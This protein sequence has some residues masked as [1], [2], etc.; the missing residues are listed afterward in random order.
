MGV[1]LKNVFTLFF[2]I[3][4]SGC[5]VVMKSQREEVLPQLCRKKALEFEE[6]GE[7][8][9]ALFNWKILSELNYGENERIEKKIAELQSEALSKAENHF[10][11][12]VVFYKNNSLKAARKEFLIVLRYNPNHKNAYA[13][14]KRKLSGENTVIYKVKEGDTL[15]DIAGK[16]Y[17][18][19]GKDFLIACFTGLDNGKV[20]AKG[21]TLIL[22][23]LSPELTRRLMDVEKRISEA[24]SYFETNEFEK[25]LNVVCDVL[26]Y[27]PN[28]K[29]A[30][31]LA[32]ASRYRIGKMLSLKKEYAHSLEMLNQI[33][34]G[35]EGV[36][37]AIAD[38][39]NRM[40]EQAEVHYTKGVKYFVN[41]QLK[42]AI[43]EWEKALALN[44]GHQKAKESVENAQGLLEK[45]DQ[46]K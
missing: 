35:Y 2:I 12:G 5:A 23:V 44:P 43:E 34:P 36:E 7:L 29:E 14:L 9:L 6:K 46:I 21:T 38:V 13:Y 31:A 41:E 25:A 45:L 33:P 42:K 26:V 20:P 11:K 1:L 17:Q 40:R 19:Q 16:V 8:H 18:D 27:D 37:E 30:K 39:T 22:P 28:N 3:Y 15:K 32:N 24:R 10:N 4:L